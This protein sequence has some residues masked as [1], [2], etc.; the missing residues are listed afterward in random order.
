MKTTEVRVL[1]WNVVDLRKKEEEFYARQFE[2]AGLVETWVEER[3]W[4]K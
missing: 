2:I 3:S 1:Y 4:E